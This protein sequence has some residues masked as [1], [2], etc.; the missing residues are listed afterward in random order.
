MMALQNV[1]FGMMS[2]YN[3]WLNWHA[4]AAAVCVWFHHTLRTHTRSLVAY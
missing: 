3:D 2:G 1:S 4:A